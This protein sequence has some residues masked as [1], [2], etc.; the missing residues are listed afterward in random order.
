M[1]SK[2]PVASLIEI[3]KSFGETVALDHTTLDVYSGEVLGLVGANGSGKTTLTSILCGYIPPDSGEVVI[4]GTSASFQSASD[5]IARG[6]R[7]LPQ[8]LEMYISLSVLENIFLG[9]EIKRKLPLLPLM[10]WKRME[11]L[12]RILLNRVDAGQIDPWSIVG[13]LSG[14]QQKA[15]ALARLLAG[16]A[17][18]LVF[19]EPAA[20]LGVRQQTRLFDIMSSEAASGRAVIFISHEIEDILSVC[21]RVVV[22]R[23]GRIVKDSPSKST[24]RQVLALQMSGV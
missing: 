24:D 11:E 7:M 14:G 22:L 17:E 6:V 10:A 19:D 4:S 8:S 9:Q 3:T 21:N 2:Q 1:L 15:V 12:A 18:V 20:S 5:A 23:K 13:H 16:Q